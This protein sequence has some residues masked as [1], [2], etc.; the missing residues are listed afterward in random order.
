MR[1]VVYNKHFKTATVK[2][3][4][5]LE[6]AVFETGRALEIGGNS[7]RLLSSEYDK[8]EE[9]AFPCMGAHFLILLTR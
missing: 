5:K 4:Q 1:R 9:S 3:V 2:L 7:L 8:Y 6:K